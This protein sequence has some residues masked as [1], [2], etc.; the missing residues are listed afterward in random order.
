MKYLEIPNA[1][2]LLFCEK[3]TFTRFFFYLCKKKEYEINKGQTDH[4]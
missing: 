2:A 1:F 4:P 3:C